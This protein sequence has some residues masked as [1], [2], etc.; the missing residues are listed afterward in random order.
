MLGLANKRIYSLEESL[1]LSSKDA[2]R[3]GDR[4]HRILADSSLVP[5]TGLWALI[6][7]INS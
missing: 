2:C 5:E 3:G 4:F 1:S 7:Y 6:Y